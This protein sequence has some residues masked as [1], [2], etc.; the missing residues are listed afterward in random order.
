MHEHAQLFVEAAVDEYFQH[1]DTVPE[2]WTDIAG[3][4]IVADVFGEDP[5]NEFYTAFAALKG[6]HPD[7]MPLLLKLESA[8]SGWATEWSD[9]AFLLGQEMG[10]KV[11]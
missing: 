11:S 1:E 3:E 2:W 4:E 8:A 9:T 5:Q 6:L 7:A 10:K